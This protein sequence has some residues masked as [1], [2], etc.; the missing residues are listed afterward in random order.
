MG[1]G[2]NILTR[3]EIVES[4]KDGVKVKSGLGREACVFKLHLPSHPYQPY[5][6]LGIRPRW[7]KHKTNI[8]FI[9]TEAEAIEWVKKSRGD[10]VTGLL[11]RIRT[12]PDEKA[13]V[14][15]VG[16]FNEPSHLD[17]TQTA[18]EVGRCG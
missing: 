16:D 4:L 8:E 18:A 9:K 10:I 13:V 6:L 5:Q 14:F 12:L 2:S 17:W 1:D 11:Q 15:V 7:H 3:Y